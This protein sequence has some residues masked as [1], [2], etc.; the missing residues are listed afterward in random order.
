MKN[1]HIMFS[2]QS[3]KAF[4]AAIL[5]AIGAITIAATNGYTL[6]EILTIIAAT[7]GA[8]QATYWTSNVDVKIGRAHV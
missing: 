8:F 1:I 5:A 6:V 3:L 4:S 2:M 7:V